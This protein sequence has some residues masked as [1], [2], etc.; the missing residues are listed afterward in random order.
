MRLHEQQRAGRHAGGGTAGECSANASPVA[1]ST[2]AT[3]GENAFFDT[4]TAVAYRSAPADRPT[5]PE[6]YVVPTTRPRH[7]VTETDDLAAALD[8]AARR[9]PGLSRS[10]LVVRLAL[11]GHRAA[12]VAHGER[13]AR[14]LAALEKHKGEFTGVY[15][16]GFLERLHA[17]WP[18]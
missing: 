14:R 7:L 1:R 16:D 4:A 12:S 3:P 5:G 6:V 15:G 8:D 10:Q 13:R 2:L 9:W 18:A 11:E 17:D